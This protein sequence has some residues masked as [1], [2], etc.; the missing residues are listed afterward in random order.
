MSDRVYGESLSLHRRLNYRSSVSEPEP[1]SPDA[2]FLDFFQQAIAGAPTLVLRCDDRDH[3]VMR[4]TIGSS[5]RNAERPILNTPGLRM[6]NDPRSS[7]GLEPRRLWARMFDDFRAI[8]R[9][10]ANLVLMTYGMF[11]PFCGAN[12]TD[13]NLHEVA[14][15]DC[16]A[17]IIEVHILFRLGN[18]YS[19][20]WGIR[21]L[22]DH[23]FRRG[24]SEIFT[25]DWMKP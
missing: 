18:G 10:S 17:R 24:G 16:F 20:P 14:E 19:Y 23:R 7:D 9:R 5:I 4:Q 15:E 11:G 25:T 13:K 12:L 1:E 6:I 3:P 2:K 8:E 22:K 21:L